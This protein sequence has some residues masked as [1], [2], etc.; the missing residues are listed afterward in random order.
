MVEVAGRARKRDGARFAGRM[1]D[2]DGRGRRVWKV[3]FVS[4]GRIDR[5]LASNV[6]RCSMLHASV[7]IKPQSSIFE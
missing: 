4:T 2:R 7:S 1:G 6:Y 5:S 3:R